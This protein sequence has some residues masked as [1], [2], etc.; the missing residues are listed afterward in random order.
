MGP[1][2][3][4]RICIPLLLVFAGCFSSSIS[5][6]LIPAEQELVGE[7]KRKI[8]TQLNASVAEV[9]SFRSLAQLNARKS[10]GDEQL[11][12]V[13]VFVR[14]DKL[15]V[16]FFEPTLAQLL[17]LI[18]VH[19]GVI[20][21]IE[22]SE[23]R[24]FVGS[25]RRE[26]IAKLLSVPLE[27]EAAMLWFVGRYALPS[28]DSVKSVALYRLSPD[29]ILLVVQDVDGRDSYVQYR[30]F[31]PTAT[32]VVERLVLVR[33]SDEQV[34]LEAKYHYVANAALPLVPSQIEVA[35]PQQDTTAV[36][37]YESPVVNPPNVRDQLFTLPAVDGLSVT[38]LDATPAS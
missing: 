1:I 12:Q 19:D 30:L 5:V 22:K 2:L 31:R 20:R 32:M 23:K 27:T 15:R 36:L 7:E 3:R 6:P 38:D 16:E 37:T 34:L 4:Y 9:R 24:A 11:K 10:F 8:V 13:V 29:T 25:A 18:V 35:L 33:Q 17:V 28:A 26:N 21:G 14:P